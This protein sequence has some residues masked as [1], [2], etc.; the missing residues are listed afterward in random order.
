MPENEANE[1]QKKGFSD[2]IVNFASKNSSI[3][4]YLVIIIIYALFGGLVYGLWFEEVSFIDAIYF[5]SIT[6]CTVGYGDIVPTTDAQ[7]L[8]TT[9]YLLVGVIFILGVFVTLLVN[10]LFDAVDRARK[11]VTEAGE[12]HVI[13]KVEGGEKELPVLETR[14]RAYGICLM[15]N[16]PLLIASFFPPIIFAIVE[17]WGWVEVIYYTVVTATTIGYGDVSPQNEW[18]RLAATFYVPFVVVTL[19]MV[20]SALSNVY[21]TRKT[22]ESEVKFLNR[23]LKQK[24]LV[25]MDVNEDGV[26]TRAEFVSFMMVAM[27]KADSE[28][29]EKLRGVFNRLDKDKNGTL[30]VAD[31][32]NKVHSGIADDSSSNNNIYLESNNEKGPEERAS[33]SKYKGD[34][35]NYSDFNNFSDAESSTMWC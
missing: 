15:K 18:I 19:T 10:D 5:T 30:T 26:V 21:M 13:D 11:S 33:E 22:H 7:K 16:L 4:T 12:I 29:V 17:G 35:G 20:M 9:F 23:K 2:G 28:L 27:G 1:T 31:L 3:L 8:Y 24:D 6:A 25:A 32:L 14:I 34:G